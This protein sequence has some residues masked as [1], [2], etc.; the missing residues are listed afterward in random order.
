MFFAFSENARG[1]PVQN[2]V[3]VGGS[4]GMVRV[5]RSAREPG[6]HLPLPPAAPSALIPCDG[7]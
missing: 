6:R 7:A 3:G 4:T 2:A 5:P 1:N